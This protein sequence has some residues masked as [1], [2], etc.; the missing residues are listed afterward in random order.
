MIAFRSDVVTVFESALYRTTSTLVHT[1]G[2]LLLADPTWL[3]SEVAA[4]RAEVDRLG[5]GRPFYLLFTHSD[6]DH[7]LGYGAFPEARTIASEAFV[8]NPEAENTLEQIRKFDDDYYLR[9]DC[10][11]SYPSIAEAIGQDG[12]VLQAG[13]TKLTFFLAP[14]HNPDG[15]FTLIEPAGILLAGDYLSNVEFPFVYHSFRAYEQTLDKAEALIRSG[16][17]RLLVPGHGDPA[18]RPSEML[19]RLADSQAYLREA[20]ATVQEGKPFPEE[21]LWQ[22]YAFRRNQASYHRANL[23]LLRLE[24]ENERP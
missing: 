6:Y 14:G 24:V 3:P 10:P 17:V 18:A 12:Q 2:L 4:I 8:R 5:R 9:R 21:A 11:L 16:R 1:S 15:L 7:I 19:R 22:R 23:E 20:R 13:D